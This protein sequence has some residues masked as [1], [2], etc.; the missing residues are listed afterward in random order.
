MTF[1]VEAVQMCKAGG[2]CKP[3]GNP[4]LPWIPTASHVYGLSQP[5]ALAGILPG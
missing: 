5:Q 1:V 3:S 4:C 2:F